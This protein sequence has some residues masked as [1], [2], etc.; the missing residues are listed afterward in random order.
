VLLLVSRQ[1]FSA[2]T[3]CLRVSVVDYGFWLWLRY[4]V[5]RF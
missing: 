3:P 2:Q 5:V 4:A 1:V